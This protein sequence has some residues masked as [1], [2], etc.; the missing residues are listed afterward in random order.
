MKKII[1]VFALSFVSVIKVTAQNDTLK[2]VKGDWGFSL[3][4]TGLINDIK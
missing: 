1:I 3:N 4:I 2:P